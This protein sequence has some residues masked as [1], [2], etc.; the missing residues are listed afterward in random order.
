MGQP[1]LWDALQK[2][3]RL[4]F[5]KSCINP[6]LLK[7]L[8]SKFLKIRGLRPC[9]GEKAFQEG[10]C[11]HVFNHACFSGTLNPHPFAECFSKDRGLRSGGTM[12]CL[13]EALQKGREG[14][15]EE[16]VKRDVL[17]HPRPLHLDRHQGPTQLCR[18]NFV[19]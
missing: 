8:F 3:K 12:P 16:E 14:T 2:K 4:L 5:S 6:G 18:R 1:G 9:L 13:G 17:V 11:S 7:S 19:L 10:C 15:H